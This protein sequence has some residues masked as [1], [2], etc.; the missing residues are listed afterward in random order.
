L[1]REEAL[2]LSSRRDELTALGV[3]M[4]AV[5]HEE[6]NSKDFNEKYWKGKIYLDA[7]KGFYK[8]IGYNGSPALYW[9]SREDLTLEEV[10]ENLVRAES[11]NVPMNREG[12][13]LIMGGVF[14]ISSKAVVYRF[15]EKI[16]G[17]HAPIS[18]VLDAA[19]KA[20]TEHR[21]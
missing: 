12:Q 9:S 13:G 14:V 10:R 17:A 5:V 20:A 2:G 7:D 16:F 4:F 21:L 19:N 6:L 11:K 3:E 18:E 1:C 8:G 15:I